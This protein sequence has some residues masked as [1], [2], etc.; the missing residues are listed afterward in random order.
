VAVSKS[1]V[2]AAYRGI[3]GRDPESSEVVESHMEASSL[4][5]LLREFVSSEEF[6]ARMR[7]VHNAPSPSPTHVELNARRDLGKW[8]KAARYYREELDQRPDDGS[9]WGKYAHA[10]KEQGL[11]ESAE[12][13][14]RRSLAVDDQVADTHLQLGHVLKCQGRH[15]DAATAYLAAYRL[16][17]SS[18]LAAAELR[19][20]PAEVASRALAAGRSEVDPEFVAEKR[21]MLCA[22]GVP[23]PVRAAISLN[24]AVAQ[25]PTQQHASKMAHCLALIA[26]RNYLPFAK[27][28]ARSFLAHHPEF[29][30]FLLLVDGDKHDAPAFDEGQVVFLSDLRLHHAGWY[31]AKFTASEFSNALKPAFLRYLSGF[32]ER[33]VY[34]DSDIAVFSSLTE[35]IDLMEVSDLVLIPHMLAPLPRPEQFWTH[36]TRADVFHSG[37][38]NAGCFA[39]NLSRAHEFLTF[40]E[41][42]NFAPGAFYEGAGYQ[43]DQQHLNWA[44]VTVPSA[45]VL[46]EGRYNVAYWNLHERDLRVASIQNRMP[47]FEVDHKPLGFYHFSGYDIGDRL[48]L[49]RHDERHSVYH[50]PAVAEIL[51]WYSDQILACP[52]AELLHE[53]YGFDQLANGFRLSRFIREL[54]KRYETYAPRFNP[55]T[56][57]GAD[58][59]CGFLMDPLPAAGSMLPLVVAAIYESRPDLQ[60]SWPGA[61]TSV[62]PDGLW[63]WF[64]RHG[65]E[66]YSLQFLIDRFRRMLISDSVCGLAEQISTVLGENQLQFFGSDRLLAVQRL[67]DAGEGNLADTLLEARTEWYFFSDLTAAFK[68]YMNRPDIQKTFPDI[69]DRDHPAFCDWLS[70]YAPEAHDCPPDIGERFRRHIGIVSLARIFSYLA[71]REDIAHRYQDSLLSDNPE[72]VIRDLIRGA[73]EGLEYDLDDVIV[74]QHIHQTSRHLLV[75]LYL[76][77]P[78]VRQ[79]PQASRVV[80]SNIASLPEYVRN[81]DWAL[82]GCEIHAACFDRFEAHLCDELRRSGHALFPPPRHVLDFLRATGRGERGIGV[83]EHAYHRAIE[84]LSPDEAAARNLGLHLKER[85]R[86]PGSNIFGYFASDIGVGESSRGLAQAISLLR[87]VNRVPLWTSH[88]RDGIELSDLFQRFDYLT[89]TNVFVSYPHQDQDLLGMMRPEHLA[90]R[91]N[92]AHL[93]WEQKDAN[94]WWKVVYD[95]YDEIWTISAFAAT[96]FRTMFPGRVRV[97][98][99]VLN[100]DEF[101]FD[102]EVS[103]ARLRNERIKFLFVFEANSSM[104]RKNPEG[105][106]DAFVKAFKDTHHAKRVQLTLKVGSLHRPEHAARV[107]RLMRKASESGLAI[108][109]D[110]RQLARNALL[111]LIAEADCYVSLH[112]AEGFGYTMAEAMFY[113]VPVIASGYSGNLEYMTPENSFLVPCKEEFVKTGEGPFQ[114]GSIWGEPDIDI[115]ATLMRQTVLMPTEYLRIGGRGRDAVLQQLSAATVAETIR[116]F[117]ASLE[118]Q[119][120]QKNAFTQAGG[121]THS[122]A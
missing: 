50:L 74:L 79:R 121:Q 100:F 89:D 23:S 31:A 14:Y 120:V 56:Q 101:P 16:D 28:A 119:E 13:A 25:S 73:G 111:R 3:H 66:E 82:R 53:P 95:R 40:W 122:G 9:I 5:E 38:V 36:P 18:S 67:R 96:A 48:R 39:I 42:A 102:E 113:G 65:G 41:E 109:F 19:T 15:D 59:L 45:R 54:L 24:P 29:L 33:V 92:V 85:Y 84:R 93:A 44:L 55:G 12:A 118:T 52:T 43:T 110:G 115:A 99:N 30:A 1:E 76:E 83:V 71:R 20:L 88:L 60:R 17:P 46:R 62:S 51:N 32:V 78:L 117:F 27:L 10:L 94:P 57:T 116:P 61:H 35:M 21:E 6:T 80:K 58:A 114:R 68:I 49:S 7:A 97:V 91:R 37:L 98:P 34:L 47:Q 75:P 86:Q 103:R 112:H 22:L 108:D 87:P 8:E 63:R 2:I 26:T 11:F 104:E 105:V 81:T 4:E 77:L 107:E 70:R 72:A 106:I 90:G 69:L 64:C